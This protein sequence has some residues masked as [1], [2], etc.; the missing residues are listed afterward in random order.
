MDRALGELRN[1]P[2]GKKKL[3][4]SSSLTSLGHGQPSLNPRPSA[5]AKDTIIAHAIMLLAS[6]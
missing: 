2:K 5:G 1:S 6:S 3:K 4:C